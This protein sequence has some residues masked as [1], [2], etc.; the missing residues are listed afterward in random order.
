[1]SSK[2]ISVIIP[3][4][5]YASVLPRAINSVMAQLADAS[6]E[7]LVIDD[8]SI[9]DTPAVIAELHAMHG[10]SF[11]A[12]RKDNGGLASVRN[13][14][15]NL[16][17]GRYLIFLDAD[18]EM[19]PGA[20]AALSAHID[21]YPETRMVI[22]GH[23]SVE[24]NGRRSIHPAAELAS[25]PDELLKDYLFGKTLSLCN[26]AC[27]MH[28]DVFVSGLYP[29]HIRNAE[30][31]PVFAQVLAR[32]PCTVLD[33]PMAAIHKH[34]TSLRRNL[35]YARQTGLAL[36]DEVFSAERMPQR[37]QHLRQR[38]RAQRCLSLFRLLSGAGHED[39]AMSYY[40][41]AVKAHPSVL[42]RWSYTRKALRILLRLTRR[43][44]AS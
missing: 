38:Y 32:F 19:L 35:N 18:D 25:S 12:V 26:G 27:A 22:A 13:Q 43:R 2:L 3:A 33:V 28:R 23:H 15:I 31:I 10:E 39:E 41:E 1:M 30:D 34:P 17:N 16:A 36:V 21:R 11:T 5:N 14:G 24:F 6:A 29:E 4:Y 44:R 37:F 9:D 42:L 40:R 7:L 8:G 20:L